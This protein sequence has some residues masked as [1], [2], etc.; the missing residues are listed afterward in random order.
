MP[1]SWNWSMRPTVPG[2]KKGLW[3]RSKSNV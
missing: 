1:W 2:L 3:I